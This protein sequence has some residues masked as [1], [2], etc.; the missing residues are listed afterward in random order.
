MT[1]RGPFQ[2]VPFYDS[3]I[4]WFFCIS[5]CLGKP[6]AEVSVYEFV[7]RYEEPDVCFKNDREQLVGLEISIYCHKEQ[8]NG[9][10]FTDRSYMA[11]VPT[12]L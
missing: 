9:N 6:T 12:V 1:H 2:P 5:E 4:L 8:I 11:R 7:G 3:V 10:R